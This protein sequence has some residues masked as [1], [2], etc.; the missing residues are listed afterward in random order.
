MALGIDGFDR[1]FPDEAACLEYVSHVRFGPELMC[2]K[3]QNGRLYASRTRPKRMSCKSAKCEVSIGAGTVF[4]HC[5]GSFRDLL[6][7]MLIMANSTAPV[8]TS[9][10]ERHFGISRMAAYRMLM[11]VRVHIAT[12]LQH[13]RRGGPGQIV[14]I[15]ET[16]YPKVR[17]TI[18][19]ARRG[20][21]VFGIIDE[22]GASVRLVS[23]RR[24]DELWPIIMDTVRKGSVIVT[25][26]HASYAG[27]AAC[28]FQ[29]VALNHSRGQWTD[30]LGH[31]SAMIES[32]WTSLKYFMRF[33]NGSIRGA[34]AP[35]YLAEHVFKF[36][37]RRA[38][39]CAFSAMTASFPAL[40]RE[41]MPRTLL[42]FRSRRPRLE[43]SE[44]SASG[45]LSNAVLNP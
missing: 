45:T 39:A 10:V 41:F 32:Y 33:A 22:A 30:G 34:Y 4:D 29:H 11:Q 38:G 36:N 25:D 3:C 1:L 6:Y 16:W 14:Q 7:L 24:K 27:L 12:L 44:T 28:G 35:L 15:D 31:S 23:T 21:I 40:N 26:R 37:V 9:F 20:I 18:T 42:A 43:S 2:P 5:R 8:S 19:G 13:E 17:G